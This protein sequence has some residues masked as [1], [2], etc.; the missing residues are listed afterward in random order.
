MVSRVH[1]PLCGL[2]L[3]LATLLLVLLQAT[4]QAT[5]SDNP[6]LDS[7]TRLKYAH[8]YQWFTSHG[9]VATHVGV[10]NFGDMGLGIVAKGSSVHSGEEILKIPLSICFGDRIVRGVGSVWRVDGKVTRQR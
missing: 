8:F 6:N 4:A 3:I 9:G 1:R 7:H 2:L 10:D 5:D